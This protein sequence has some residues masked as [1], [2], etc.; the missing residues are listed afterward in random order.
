MKRNL[1]FA[2]ILP[3]EIIKIFIPLEPTLYYNLFKGAEARNFPS[4]LHGSP[5]SHIRKFG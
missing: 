1:Q 2:E 4:L 3:N 5:Q